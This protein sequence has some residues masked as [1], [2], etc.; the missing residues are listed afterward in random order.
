ME[1][2]PFVDDTVELPAPR[3]LRRMSLELRGVLP[4]VAELDA[5]ET[6]AEALS[7]IAEDYLQDP[8]LE[9]RIV[10]LL[11]E[12][13]HTRVDSFDIRYYDYGLAD[14]QEFAFERAIGEEPLRL[15]ANIVVHD[16][17]WSDIVTADYTMANDL[18]GELWPLDYP[19]GWEGWHPVHY[20][21]GRPAVGILA[22]NGLWWRYP[23]SSFNLSRSRVAAAARILVCHDFLARPV[24]FTATPSLLDAESTTDAVRSV[25]ACLG[26]HSAI[27][28]AAAAMFGFVPAVPY[29]VDE[30]QAYHAE[31]ERLGPDTLGVE[32]A[33]FGT[34]ISG[35][36]ELGPAIAADPRFPTCAVRT[37][38]S[39]LWR[40]EVDAADTER[41]APLDVAFDAGEWRIRPL[42]RAILA[43]ATF[44]ADSVA[45]APVRRLLSPDQ[46]ATVLGD[47]AGFT[48][49]ERGFEQLANDEYGY[50][51]L[52]GGVNGT[53]VL[54]PQA[55]PGLT[56]AMT[57]RRVT[58]ASASLMAPSY[59]GEDVNV[60]LPTL[61][62]QLYAEHPSAEDLAGWSGLWS[63]VA[64]AEGEDAAWTATIAAM[65]QDPAMVTE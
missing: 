29:N 12:R 52:A 43:S 18:L 64:A 9:E 28:P 6:D 46:L 62:W 36:A 13:W 49:E 22:T 19:P 63:A 56:W 58:E 10:A 45:G 39:A 15:A 33:W 3:L 26:C 55:T 14:D 50:R 17:P 61:A 32:P 8:R 59:A 30:V 42:L 41:L 37:F 2:E 34:P 23:T 1:P 31:R 44:R 35:L 25:D 16:L 57:V 4:S 20:T 47:L 5:V 65:L 60:A 7:S 21:D 38:A 54:M 51:V 53:N 24:T 40:R 11:A 27:E 48:W